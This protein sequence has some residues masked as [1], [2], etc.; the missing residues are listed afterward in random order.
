MRLILASQ[1]ASRRAM[2]TA[3]GAP[4]EAMSPGVDEDAAKVGLRDNGISARDLADALAEFK[5][6]RLSQRMQGALVLGCDSTVALDDG[7][8]IDKAPDR[9]VLAGQL[10]RMAGTTHSLYSAAVIAENGQPVW[11]HVDRAKMTMRPMSDDFI[12]TYLAEEGDVLLGCVGGYR[13][14]GRGAQLFAKIEGSQ[15]TI[16]GLPLLP[17][18]DYL[19]V[20]GVMTS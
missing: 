20:R 3:A 14:E 17:L 19:R 15:F 9:A 13:I 5:A 12:D 2:L 4:F 18:L 6:L 11:R 7:T 8:M 10:R 1:S 16:M